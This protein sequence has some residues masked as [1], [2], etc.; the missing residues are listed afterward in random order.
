MDIH[1][2][3]ATTKVTPVDDRSILAP[4]VLPHVVRE[5]MRALES[6]SARQTQRDE[7]TQLWGSVRAG[8]GR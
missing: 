1:I 6:T 4:D 3:K 8:T 5:V 7:D 2:G